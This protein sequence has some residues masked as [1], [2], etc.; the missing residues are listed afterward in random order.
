M[1][2]PKQPER[3]TRRAVLTGTGTAAA[4]LLLTGTP[5]VEAASKPRKG[6]DLA[7]LIARTPLIDTHEHLVEEERRTGWSRPVSLLPCNDWALLFSHYLNSDLLVAGMTAKDY[8]TFTAPDTAT[9]RKWALLEPWW[10]AVKL[11]GYGRAVRLALG[12]LYGAVA[13][14]SPP[15]RFLPAPASARPVR[16]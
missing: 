9:N 13:P 5:F 11:T 8:A 7:S 12:Q 10:P 1:N 6:D 3:I 2:T 14:R 15:G 16:P 4:S